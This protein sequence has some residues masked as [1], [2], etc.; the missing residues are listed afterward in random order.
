MSLPVYKQFWLVE[1][2]KRKKKEWVG[3]SLKTIVLIAA[4]DIAPYY[5]SQCFHMAEGPWALQ[6]KGS[7]IKYCFLL[8]NKLIFITNGKYYQKQH[9][10][11][12]CTC[13]NTSL[14]A[15]KRHFLENI[16]VLT[17][18]VQVTGFLPILPF[19]PQCHYH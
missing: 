19:F 12:Q 16:A 1:R 15:I 17:C 8:P 4:K 6:F 11:S 13:L 14:W 10:K 3:N 18:K 2:E 9:F 7:I 5:C